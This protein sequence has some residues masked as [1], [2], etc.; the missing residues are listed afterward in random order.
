LDYKFHFFPWFNDETYAL[1]PKY[2][3]I[4]DDTRNYFKSLSET[5]N[6]T[7][8]EEQIAWYQVKSDEQ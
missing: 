6:L 5:L 1:E 4:T 3:I 7:F 8:S 2:A